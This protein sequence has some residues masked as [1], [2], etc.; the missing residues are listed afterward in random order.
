MKAPA[1][2]NGNG[3]ARLLAF[4]GGVVAIAGPMTLG[5]LEAGS[6]AQEATDVARAALARLAEYQEKTSERLARLETTQD[7]NVINVAGLDTTL[8]REMRLLDDKTNASSL[9]VDK[10]LQNEMDL[11][12][13]PLVETIRTSQMRW[14]YWLP[15][16]ARLETLA[17]EGNK[18]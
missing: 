15:R 6:K 9:E 13:S 14:E 18:P 4:L 5:I 3:V 1:N 16:M 17:E 2:G 12:L 7:Q 8:Q 10:R 11:K